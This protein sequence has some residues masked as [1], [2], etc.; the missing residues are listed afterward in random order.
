MLTVSRIMCRVSYS[1]LQSVHPVL[2]A[3]PWEIIAVF[4]KTFSKTTSKQLGEKST[5]KRHFGTAK[6]RHGVDELVPGSAGGVADREL[7]AAQKKYVR[8]KQ[9]RRLNLIRTFR[10]KDLFGS[11][12]YSCYPRWGLVLSPTKEHT[13]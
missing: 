2:P 12:C 13:G 7:P 8:T 6:H 4:K 11:K 9:N 5:E 3:N 10:R 1:P